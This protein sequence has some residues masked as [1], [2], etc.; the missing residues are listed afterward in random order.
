MTFRT[1][2]PLRLAAIASITAAA[3][4]AAPA[5]AW[6]PSK[7]VEFIVPAGTGGGADQMARLIDGIVK[8]H[9]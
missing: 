8:K 9:K 3:F 4:V 2:K 7:T 5:N 1:L 6:E